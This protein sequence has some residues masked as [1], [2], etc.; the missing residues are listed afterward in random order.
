MVFLFFFF[1]GFLVSLLDVF[2]VSLL[3]ERFGVLLVFMLLGYLYFEK[4]NLYIWV[5]VLS[6]W[7]S[8][9]NYM[10][11]FFI[12]LFFVFLY[13]IFRLLFK[14]PYSDAIRI[15]IGVV[16]VTIIYDLYVLGWAK[17]LYYDFSVT[18]ILSMVSFWFVQVLFI[19]FGLWLIKKGTKYFSSQVK[20]K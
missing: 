15:V 19:Y 13:Y 1:I 10:N 2:L 9:F 16:V 4:V 17:F 18:S 14:I 8:V 12:F 6:I 5:A 3:G 11:P 20:V 7:F